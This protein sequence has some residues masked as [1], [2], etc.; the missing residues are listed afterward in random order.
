VASDRFVWYGLTNY[1][2]A[3]TGLG[4]MDPLHFTADLTPAYATDL[5]A[6]VQGSVT[7]VVTFGGKLWFTVSGQG[8]WREHTAP[9]P[10]GTVTSG[11]M[12]WGLPDDKNA[13]FMD[14]L[15]EPLNGEID[16]SLVANDQTTI[17]AGASTQAGTVTS[18]EL[19]V[20]QRPGR[21]FT[22]VAT[23]KPKFTAG[24]GT[25]G[26]LFWTAGISPVL[27]RITVHVWPNP[28]RVNHINLPLL[29]NETLTAE[30][31]AEKDF[32]C[33]AA[34]QKIQDLL[35]TG[36]YVNLQSGTTSRRVFLFD[37]DFIRDKK[38]TDHRGFQGTMVLTLR[39][40]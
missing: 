32:D 12:T 6:T 4:R 8:G 18:G 26:N 33:V 23:L 1:D 5:M 35:A 24:Q 38:T 30:S 10:S 39:E 37:K 9:V 36:R 2:T 3:S 27:N 22:M 34:E 20:G 21:W 29:F 14:A 19:E 17:I 15:H 13:L 28:E 7:S 16:L 31:G 25:P 11:R 40:L